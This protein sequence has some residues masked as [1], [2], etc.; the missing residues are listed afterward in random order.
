MPIFGQAGKGILGRGAA[1]EDLIRQEKEVGQGPPPPAQSPQG[2]VQA[3]WYQDYVT[4]KRWEML[5]N[6]FNQIGYEQ[7]PKGDPAQLWRR[8]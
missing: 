8:G 5:K 3:P 7:A 4:M 2:V 6:W 1:L